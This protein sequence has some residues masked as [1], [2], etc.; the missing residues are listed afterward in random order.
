MVTK[1]SQLLDVDCFNIA[2]DWAEER[3]GGEGGEREGGASARRLECPT[4]LHIKSRLEKLRIFRVDCHFT[5]LEV[6]V[7]RI[8]IEIQ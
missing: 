6:K 4:S 8:L 2:L 1:Q 5:K 7:H 3:R